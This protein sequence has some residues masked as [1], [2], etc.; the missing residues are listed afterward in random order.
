VPCE[1]Q[2][3]INDLKLNKDRQ[4]MQHLSYEEAFKRLEEILNLMNSGQVPLD[5]AVALYKEADSLT[6]LCEEKLKNAE[7]TIL[8]L[9][10]DREG[11]ISLNENQE[12]IMQ[13]F[14]PSRS[15]L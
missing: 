7:N 6:K 5:K 15:S 2:T 1:S 11:Q 14:N 4:P 13:D 10:K 12:P 8:T 3:K 9:V